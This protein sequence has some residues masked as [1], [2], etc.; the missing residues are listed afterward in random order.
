MNPAL[1]EFP[2][3]NIEKGLI[4]GVS[5]GRLVEGY[6]SPLFIFSERVIKQKVSELRNA[7]Q[8]YYPNSQIAYSLKANYLPAIL[9]TLRKEHIWAE[10]ESEFEYWLSKKLGFSDNE[11]IFN[12]VDKEEDTLFA[13]LSNGAVVNVGNFPEL[14]RIGKFTLASDKS[15]SI[16]LQIN[17]RV[18]SR[19]PS[20]HGFELDTGEAHEAVILLNKKFSNVHVRGLH[21]HLGPY[22]ENIESYTLAAEQLSDFA[23]ELKKDFDINIM[24]LDMRSGFLV[25]G[26]R[27]FGREIWVVSEIGEY[28]KEIAAVLDRKFP[29]EKPR[30]YIEP[31]KFLVDEAGVLLTTARDVKITTLHPEQTKRGVFLRARDGARGDEAKLQMVNVDAS[32]NSVLPTAPLRHHR[33]HAISTHRTFGKEQFASIVGGNSSMLNDFLAWDITLPQVFAGDHLLFYNAGA[34]ELY[35]S[36]GSS[37]RP[38]AIMVHSDKRVT[39]MQRR[40]SFEHLVALDK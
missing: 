8:R 35:Y 1:P 7:L 20:R 34:Y 40:E 26:A 23:I 16:G 14:E 22:I 25:P 5:I 38:A 24:Y 28:V 27:P 36:R 37:P 2:E 30:L 21:V 11:I 19:Y 31:G 18:G 29:D 3:V 13:A 39:R 4:E 33:V 10:A 12:A 17:L 32:M 9:D 15:A 6:G